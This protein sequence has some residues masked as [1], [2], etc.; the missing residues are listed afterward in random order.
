MSPAKATVEVRRVNDE[1]ARRLEGKSL[2]VGRT[3]DEVSKY[4]CGLCKG[5][6][7]RREAYVRASCQSTRYCTVPMAKATSILKTSL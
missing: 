1:L 4:V 6:Y 5:A 7:R 3:L 2:V